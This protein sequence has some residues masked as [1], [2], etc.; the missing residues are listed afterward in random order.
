MVTDPGMKPTMDLNTQCM[1]VAEAMNAMAP[2]VFLSQTNFANSLLTKIYSTVNTKPF[3]IKLIQH[4]S[5]YTLVLT[6]N[7]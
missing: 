7:Q 3:F 1:M 2:G 6:P 4:L 5:N